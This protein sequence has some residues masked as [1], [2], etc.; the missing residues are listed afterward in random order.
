VVSRLAAG[1]VE[2]IVWLP[3]AYNPG[4]RAGAEVRYGLLDPDGRERQA[5]TM[6]AGL[7]SAARGAT[8]SPIR[9]DGLDGVAFSGRDGTRMVVWSA[10]A[11]VDV[12]LPVRP[13]AGSTAPAEVA[14]TPVLVESDQPLDE[15]LDALRG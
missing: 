13:L 2:E 10:A 3:L 15:A 12:E 6:L 1:G 4:N 5:G 8:A 9:Q 7:A 14:T 11:P